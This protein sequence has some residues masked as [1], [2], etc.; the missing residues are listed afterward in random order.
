MLPFQGG[1]WVWEI[2]SSPPPNSHENAEETESVLRPH[3]QTEWNSLRDVM[4]IDWIEW[5]AKQPMSLDWLRSQMYKQM[6][7]FLQS[8]SIHRGTRV[9]WKGG[10]GLWRSLKQETVIVA[11]AHTEHDS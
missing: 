9:R 11:I 5:W 4:Q 3:V 2:G 6:D 10:G 7:K 1:I 8:T